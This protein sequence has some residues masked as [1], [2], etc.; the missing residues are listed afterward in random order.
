M[1]EQAVI[2][3][4]IVFA[5]W[6]TMQEGEIF[7]FMQKYSYLKIAP[8]LFDCP[9]CMAPWYGS[10][11]YVIIWGVNWHWPVIVITAMGINAV[12]NKLAPKEEVD[13]INHY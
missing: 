1:L 11:I 2:I 12:I 6:F 7:G 13:V 4:F 9:V 8:A 3:A 10:I 5:I